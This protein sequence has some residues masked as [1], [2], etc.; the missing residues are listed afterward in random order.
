MAWASCSSYRPLVPT[1][2]QLLERVRKICL[3]LPD[4][5]EKEAWS[6]PTFRIRGKK[7]FA[8]YADNHHADG[9]VAL[10]LAAE[11]GVQEMLAEADLER[12]FVPPYQGPYGWIGVRVDGRVDWDEIED[13]VRDAFRTT[14]PKTL[15]ARLGP[16]KGAGRSG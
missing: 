13:L 3:A 5:T 16:R 10:W 4:A 9:R 1:R 8:M 14:A 6:A 12:F 7:M 11:P 2:G 15:V